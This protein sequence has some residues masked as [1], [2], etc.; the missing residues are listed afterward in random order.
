MMAVQVP[1]ATRKLNPQHRIRSGDVESSQR[2]EA[3]SAEAVASNDRIV[4]KYLRNA[5]EKG[6]IFRAAD[7]SDSPVLNYAVPLISLSIP[8][9][10]ALN[11]FLEPGLIVDIYGTVKEQDRTSSIRLIWNL[12]LQS[13]LDGT[14]S[15][16]ACILI[17]SLPE[18]QPE[19]TARLAALGTSTNLFIVTRPS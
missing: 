6:E 19:A 9:S 8:A 2:D 3:S 11:G 18:G 14:G 17:L 1:V 13:V 16:P 12:T 5:K 15:D 4:N 7:L 10:W